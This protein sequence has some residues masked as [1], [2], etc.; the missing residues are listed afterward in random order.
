MPTLPSGTVTFLFTDIEGS[1]ALWEAQPQE[2]RAALAQHDAILR[3]AIEDCGGQVF[4]TAG[5]AFFAAFD[6]APSAIAAAARAQQELAAAHW[7]TASPV[8]ARMAIHTGFAE[9]VN[10]DYV[11]A[12]LNRI[13]RLITASHGGQTLL[14]QATEQLARDSL[15]GDARLVDLGQHRF[16]DLVAPERVFQLSISGLPDYFPPLKTLNATPNNL[17][18]QLTS[19]IGRE[20]E[21]EAIRSLL[22]DTH[23][24]TLTGPGGTG[25]TRLALQ[26]AAESAERYPDGVWLVELAPVVDPALVPQTIATALNLRASSSQPPMEQVLSA[27]R[28]KD[29]MLVLDNCEHLLDAC[30]QVVDLL[31]KNCP[32]LKMI[33]SS[34]EALGIAGEVSYRVPPLHLPEWE[35]FDDLEALGQVESICLF[36]KR[37]QAASPAFT[38]TRQNARAVVQICRR[39]DGIP[40]AIELAAARVKLFSAEQIAA[41]LDDRFKLLT[42]GS[43]SALPRQQ[44]LQAAIDWSYT[45]LSEKEKI[46]FRRLS[47]FAGGWSYDAAE[48]IC[49]DETDI[50]PYELMDL[51]AQLINKSLVLADDQGEEA[52][53]R[54]LETIRQYASEK[55]VEAG[56]AGRLRERHLAYFAD[57]AIQRGQVTLFFTARD[58][59]EYRWLDR[60]VDNLR[61]A[62]EWAAEHDPVRALQMAA[63][64]PLWLLYGLSGEK[65][66]YLH[67]VRARFLSLPEKDEVDSKNNQELLALSWVAEGTALMAQGNYAGS[68]AAMNQGLA[69]ARP[70]HADRMMEPMLGQ[71]SVAYLLTGQMELA[72]AASQEGLALVR[73]LEDRQMLGL[74]LTVQARHVYKQQGYAAALQV[75]QRTMAEMGIEK[76]H[77]GHAWVLMGM[78]TLAVLAGEYADAIR[79]AEESYLL[80]EQNNNHQYLNVSRS[81]LADVARL[82]GEYS[83]AVSLY[84]EIIADWMV[85]GNRGAVARCLECLASIALHQAKGSADPMP[86]LKRAAS[87][88]AA[89][90]AIRTT[91]GA[92]M[93]P[94]EKPEVAA[95]LDI[96]HK[97]LPE[98][99]FSLAWSIGSG[100]SLERA[101]EFARQ[102][103]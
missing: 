10:G 89:A 42:G 77:Y 55:L 60:E 64:Y 94:E 3:R 74:F 73:R 6:A 67:R 57:Q 50:D 24:L 101:V 37:A 98:P 49:T 69:V 2:M 54:T 71:L 46:L 28:G 85:I 7:P 48:A 5:D 58:S 11:G 82:T 12:S 16:R 76:E 4:R 86:L 36:V 84:M 62:E 81:T 100:L 21:L 91:Y 61:L 90:E 39:L 35:N 31:L 19:F 22:S 9:V 92:E 1:T 38:L 29:L 15:P 103:A 72:S 27:V 34:R 41:R 83:R 96:L 18:V 23:L 68:I 13:G 88:F 26:S 51:L 44:T 56:E 45:L 95:W 8:R 20:H 52:R 17:P 63:I 53:Y 97:Q 87:L 93:A 99:D 75:Y 25:K 102:L 14:T 40:L 32:N 70:I 78:G 80:F 65:I 43:R 33:T 66:E 59:N 79:F 30:A 47:V